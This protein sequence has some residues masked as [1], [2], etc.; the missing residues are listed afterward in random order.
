MS[1]TTASPPEG[2]EAATDT[3]LL[4]ARLM[5]EVARRAMDQGQ[6][7]FRTALQSLTEAQSPMPG[8]GYKDGS[9]V[10]VDG[11]RLAEACNTTVE[12]TAADVEALLSAA[13]CCGRGV[14]EWQ[15]GRME[16]SR[17]ALDQFGD[18]M[19]ALARSRSLADVAEV[20]RDLYLDAMANLVQANMALFAGIS[21]TAEEARRSLHQKRAPN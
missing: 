1:A 14:Q 10:V 21:K 19:Q 15:R 4:P 17:R 20:Q 3:M 9:A 16:D 8:W 6:E 2:T 11:A 5:A 18:R 13:A 7:A 12:R